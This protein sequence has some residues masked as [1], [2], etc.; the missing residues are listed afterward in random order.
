[1]HITVSQR[2]P[3]MTISRIKKDGEKEYILLHLPQGSR[4]HDYAIYDT[5]YDENGNPSNKWPH[6]FRFDKD[7]GVMP[8]DGYVCL[9]RKSYKPHFETEAYIKYVE[10]KIQTPF[11]NEDGDKLH[12][13][14]IAE[15]VSKTVNVE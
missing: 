6:F 9:Y 2:K 12:L 3:N 13:I 5:T 14:K 1:M 10:M 7:D 11:I 4:L 15:T 8:L